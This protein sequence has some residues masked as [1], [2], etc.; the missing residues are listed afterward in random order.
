MGQD[1]ERELCSPTEGPKSGVA[2]LLFQ[3]A[4]FIKIRIFFFIKDKRLAGQLH[5]KSSVYNTSFSEG[6]SLQGTGGA[7]SPSES[8]GDLTVGN[9]DG[10]W[11]GYLRLSGGRSAEEFW[12]PSQDVSLNKMGEELARL[13][14]YEAECTRKDAV[15]AV[16]REEVEAMQKQ[17]EQLQKWQATFLGSTSVEVAALSFFA[18]LSRAWIAA[19]TCLLLVFFFPPPSHPSFL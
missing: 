15:I 3:L 12:F 14:P 7:C 16:L 11:G 1:R 6:S 10:G 5:G 8:R 4:K 17:L 19:R 9:L 2:W 13:A 18:S